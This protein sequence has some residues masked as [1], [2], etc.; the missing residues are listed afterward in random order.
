M[1][2]MHVWYLGWEDHLE[3]EMATHSA[4]L[5]W[6]ISWI[7]KL[8]GLQSVGLKELD[9]RD[10]VHRYKTREAISSFSASP[11]ESF[12]CPFLLMTLFLCSILLWKLCLLS[13]LRCWCYLL[14]TWPSAHPFIF[15][16]TVSSLLKLN[17]F[18]T[19]S[20]ELFVTS[21]QSMRLLLSTNCELTV[22]LNPLFRVALRAN[23]IIFSLN[24]SSSSK[25]FSKTETVG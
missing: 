7:E 15:L 17:S 16:L 18:N 24:G 10:W 8:G 13:C 5:A 21:N 23:I 1:Q 25:T 19:W 12:L 6:K 20:P 14:S 4:V 9:T 11:E 22:S 2:E 3:E